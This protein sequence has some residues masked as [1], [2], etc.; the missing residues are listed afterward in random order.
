VC[1]GGGIVVFL[2]F[3]NL[4]FGEYIGELMPGYLWIG[5]VFANLAQYFIVYII[6]VSKGYSVVLYILAGLNGIGLLVV[7]SNQLKGRWEN[8][9][10]YIEFE[11]YLE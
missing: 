11:C 6:D 9:L 2:D 4:A 8:S 5:C 3:T 7:I 1:L 10:N